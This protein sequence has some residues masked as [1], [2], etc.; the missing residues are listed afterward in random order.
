MLITLLF[1]PPSYICHG[2]S[3]K[4]LFL[5]TTDCKRRRTAD[6]RLKSFKIRPLESAGHTLCPHLAQRSQSDHCP[7][8]IMAVKVSFPERKMVR[9]GVRNWRVGPGLEPQMRWFWK[10]SKTV[11]CQECQI[12]HWFLN[13]H[14]HKAYTQVWGYCSPTQ[15]YP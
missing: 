13:E 1:C 7:N 4:P 8:S 6:A 11:S 12:E 5:P 3:E 10:C 14:D 9:P 2:A 15:A